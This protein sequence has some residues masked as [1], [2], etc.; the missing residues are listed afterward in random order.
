MNCMCAK[1]DKETTA[2]FILA[3]TDQFH[4][5]SK[6]IMNVSNIF[7]YIKKVTSSGLPN[8]LN[9]QKILDNPRPGRPLPNLTN[10]NVLK[11]IENLIMKPE[12]TKIN[13][14]Y[15]YASRF[16]KTTSNNYLL[17]YPEFLCTSK[18]TPVE[19]VK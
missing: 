11:R 16:G 19:H 12:V 3:K 17:Q 10:A 7:M 2:L 1:Y 5:I 13:A 8:S 9:A 4:A 15:L 18:S 6:L 14:T